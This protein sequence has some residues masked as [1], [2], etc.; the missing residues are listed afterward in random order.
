M[1]DHRSPLYLDLHFAEKQNLTNTPKD[2]QL[3]QSSYI[4]HM[5][6]SPH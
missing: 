3:V 4:D 5:V 6:K 1:G 2:H